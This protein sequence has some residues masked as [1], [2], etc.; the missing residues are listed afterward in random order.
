[1]VI[2]AYYLSEGLIICSLGV[3]AWRYR[4]AGFLVAA[5][6]FVVFLVGNV[7]MQRAS[8]SLVDAQRQQLG[9]ETLR[10]A[11]SLWREVS[12]V[13]FLAGGI[14]LAVAALVSSRRRATT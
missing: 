13:G 10:V 7:E 8:Q 3:L 5:L 11:Y 1:V 14:G 2:Y 4:S 9:L 6:G 12:S